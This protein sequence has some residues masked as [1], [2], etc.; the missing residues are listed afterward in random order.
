M[1]KSIMVMMIVFAF[2]FAMQVQTVHATAELDLTSGLTTV[3]VTDGSSLDSNTAVG[4]ITYIGTVGSTWFINVS[5][6]VT[7]PLV[8]SA[9]KPDLD[10][11]SVNMSN[12]AGTL[13]IR[14]FD[15]GFGPYSGSLFDE[16][17][18]TAAGTASYLAKLDGTTIASL[19]PF[20]PGAFS[21]SISSGALNF[22]TG[23][24]ELD[25]TITHTGTGSQIS[26]FD[27]N[28]HSVPEPG[29]L[30]MFGSSLVGLAFFRRRQS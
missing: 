16:V 1:K 12:G 21:G 27:N 18:G 9:T 3:T 29:M 8:G 20:G 26:S 2:V 24:L 13:N 23:T 7:K 30:L 15:D 17:G 28:L 22:S 5:T 14:F 6:G 11:N 19:G 10:L 4:A 25:A